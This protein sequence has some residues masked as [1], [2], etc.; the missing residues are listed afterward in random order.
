MKKYR[1]FGIINPLDVLIV[2]GLVALVW[3][4]YIFSVPREVTADGGTRI[5]Y[6]VEIINMEEGFHETI[7]PGAIVFDSV[8]GINIGVVAE[9]Y[10]LPFL[11]DVPD[12]TTNQFQ[13][14][15]VAGR[16]NTYIIVEAFANIC[17]YAVAVGQYHIRVG[18]QAFVRSRDFGG[19][20]RITR[21]EIFR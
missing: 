21:L 15:E 14:T 6:T 10:A 13:R 11:T 4:A 12:E 17:D 2:A 16:E 19:E 7:R 9:T 18:R 1:L 20:A 5:R 8:L 3:G